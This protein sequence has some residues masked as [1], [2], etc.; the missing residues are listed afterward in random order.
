MSAYAFVRHPLELT[1]DAWRPLDRALLRWVLAHGGSSRLA[2]TAAWASLADGEGDTA[3]LLR[4]AAAP[5]ED[6]PAWSEDDVA[7]LRAQ[8]M[9]AADDVGP[10]R[11]FVLDDDGRF[12]LW[13][14]R[15]DES[16]VIAAVRTRRATAVRVAVADTDIDLLFDGRADEAV[17][18]QRAAVR[19]VAGRRLFVLTG[20][21]GTGKTT[22]VLRMLLMLQRLAAA[23]LAIAA[24][25][26]T[27]KAAQR[28]AQSL[29]E[30]R[31]DLL[32]R[33]S[34]PLPEAWRALLEHVPDEAQTLHRLLG[35]QPWNGR[36]ARHAGDPLA[37]DVVVVDEASMIDLSM[38]RALLEALRPEATLILVGDAD[39]LASIGAGSALMDLVAVMEDDGAGD[40]VR[41]RH[42]FRA[43][44]ALA[45]VHE[46]VR[47][48]DVDA[49]V[50]A[51]RDAGE[52]AIAREVADA[53]ALARSLRAWSEALAAA[54]PPPTACADAAGTAVA[55]EALRSHARRQ[56]LCA[57]REGP[58]GSLSAAATIERHLRASW[59]VPDGDAWYP[60]RAVMV[61]RNDYA[62][63]LFNGDVGLCLHDAV[64][65]PRVWFESGDDAA[66]RSRD[67]S[68]QRGWFE[69]GDDAATRS[70]DP[71][72][73]RGWFESRD[74]AA[75]RSLDVSVQRG[76]FESGNDAATRSLDVSIQRGW[77][78]S[79]N[80]AATRSRDPDA[81]LGGLESDDGAGM[82]SLAPDAL[83][84]HESAFA[85]TVHKSQGSEYDRV[86]LLLPP[87][88]DSAIL[89]RQL[90]YTGLSRARIAVE[91]WGTDRARAAA[92]AK[93]VG[94][95]GGL[96]ARLRGR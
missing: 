47:E 46:S 19:Q 38:L 74:D 40:L 87:D 43:Q 78:E 29:R 55:R 33:A 28:L 75:T 85:I 14:N 9:V 80:D 37:A 34:P 86:V 6:L 11:P 70:R 65:N 39:Q 4:D 27:G 77:F 5:R 90:L 94:R 21:P 16:R 12:Y 15:R 93:P 57:L 1:H 35:H 45:A 72:A 82:R 89:S 41:L 92:L 79:G 73:R 2:T 17:A 3:L 24:A 69:S 10:T 31:R 83:P 25:A 88:P 67:V 76:W 63:G 49:F 36:F 64:G 52:A 44:R 84:P 68:I 60:G 91:S 8:A 22:T 26:P 20:G 23:P 53:R 58:F 51:W 59:Q 30:G 48:G 7:A 42:S 95:S 96:A 56:L 18:P 81:R 71:G 54:G 13:R 66:T 32:E 50:S 62:A 61:T